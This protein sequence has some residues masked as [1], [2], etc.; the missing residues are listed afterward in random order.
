MCTPSPGWVG[1][2]GACAECA[3]LHLAIIGRGSVHKAQPGAGP[4]LSAAAPLPGTQQPPFGADVLTGHAAARRAQPGTVIDCGCWACRVL[5]GAGHPLLAQARRQ[6][7]HLCDRG[8]RAVSTAA[9]RKAAAGVRCRAGWALVRA[10]RATQRDGGAHVSA[11]AAPVGRPRRRHA[12]RPRWP[13]CTSGRLSAGGRRPRDATRRRRPRR[14]D[15]SSHRVAAR[16]LRGGRDGQD[17]RRRRLPRRALTTHSKHAP[18]RN[19]SKPDSVVSSPPHSGHSISSCSD[20]DS[21]PSPSLSLP[22]PSPSASLDASLPSLPS[23]PSPLSPH[24]S[25]HRVQ[26]QLQPWPR[27]TQ[28]GPHR[29]HCSHAPVAL[30]RTMRRRAKWLAVRSRTR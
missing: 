17:Q 11:T 15:R 13:S 30:M 24:S 28:S 16:R 2:R 5:A 8:S 10:G 7:P 29:L 6:H 12:R 22:P 9:P 14:C 27:W 3:R 1:G 20:D 21:E 18:R 19:T 4:W 26:S 25:Q 23:L